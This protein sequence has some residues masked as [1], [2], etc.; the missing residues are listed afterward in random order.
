MSDPALPKIDPTAYIRTYVPIGV[1][2][3]LGYL[4]THVPAIA[5]GIAWLDANLP[6]GFDWR[7]LLNGVAIALVTA[8]YY[9][10]ARQ[11]GRRWPAVEGFLLGS[12]STPVYK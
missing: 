4:I 1:G 9:W 5:N 2:L 6:A 11:I 3:I 12:S 10:V 7:T 8:G